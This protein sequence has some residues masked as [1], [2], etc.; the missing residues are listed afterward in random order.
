MLHINIIAVGKLKEKFWREACDEYLKRLKPYALV[1]V[2][3]IQDVD[4]S[5]AG[6]VK[7]AI[8]R[9]SAA[10]CSALPEKCVAVL[11]DIQGKMISSENIAERIEQW[12]LDGA[13][14]VAFIIGGSH[15]VGEEVLKR[16]DVRWS[17]G[18]ITMPHNL[19]RVVLV[20]QVY[21]AF[22]IIRNE[23]YHK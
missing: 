18:R 23:P 9:E 10:I 11:L 22:K 8:K 21:R 1:R 16:A 14:N 7:D 2:V 17:F 15:G 19:A 5:G 13:S 4:P 6:G 12:S 20:E 3:E